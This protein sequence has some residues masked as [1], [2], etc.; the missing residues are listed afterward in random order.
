[1]IKSCCG[2]EPK[3]K[4]VKLIYT[5]E[6]WRLEEDAHS[7]ILENFRFL[8]CEDGEQKFPVARVVIREQH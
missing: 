4:V 2:L 6:L 3:R 1:M 7:K 5:F 8:F